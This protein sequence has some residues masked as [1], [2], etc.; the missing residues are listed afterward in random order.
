MVPEDRRIHTR[1][2]CIVGIALAV[3]IA[4]CG[5]PMRLTPPTTAEQCKILDVNAE[6]FPKIRVLLSARDRSGQPAR[7]V[8]VEKVT[9]E[10]LLDT[11]ET[12]FLELT[13]AEQASSGKRI[14]SARVFLVCDLRRTLSTGT[15]QA[16]VKDLLHRH[17]RVGHQFALVIS[18]PYHD[19][20]DSD[21]GQLKASLRAG[22]S[23]DRQAISSAISG[24]LPRGTT[25]SLV[26]DGLSRALNVIRKDSP[27]DQA[28]SAVVV[29]SGG[30]ILGTSVEAEQAQR[31]V[32]ELVDL[33]VSVVV[34][35]FDPPKA[36][37]APT[38][39]E[40]QELAKVTGGAFV[41]WRTGDDSQQA[42]AVQSKV[43]ELLNHLHCL[44]FKSWQLDPERAESRFTVKL[45]TG[46][47]ILVGTG[48]FETRRDVVEAEL[49]N[50]IRTELEFKAEEARQCLA[51]V[52]A[53]IK[54]CSTK[55]HDADEALRQGEP[56]RAL[57]YVDGAWFESIQGAQAE[58]DQLKTRRDDGTLI[59]VDTLSRL[60]RLPDDHDLRLKW[61]RA[62]EQIKEAESRL[63]GWDEEGHVPGRQADRMIADARDQQSLAA[64]LAR[65]DRPSVKLQ[66]IDDL[67]AYLHAVERMWPEWDGKAA[68]GIRQRFYNVAVEALE[69]V[70]R[71]AE[72]VQHPDIKRL[73]E[74]ILELDE[75]LTGTFVLSP[76]PHRLLAEICRQ[77]D[78]FA[79]AKDHCWK[80]HVDRGDESREMFRLWFDTCLLGGPQD[81]KEAARVVQYVPSGHD[82]LKAQLLMR[83]GEA[84]RAA[85]TPH[86]QQMLEPARKAY[87]EAD[88]LLSESD[89]ARATRVEAWCHIGDLSSQLG[90]LEDAVNAYEQALELADLAHS[91]S[92]VFPPD[93]VVKLMQWYLLL[94]GADGQGWK[95]VKPS[96]EQVPHLERIKELAELIL[97]EPLLSSADKGGALRAR[98]RA[99][100]LT[101]DPVGAAADVAEAKRLLPSDAP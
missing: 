96:A 41:R 95:E 58:V 31:I 89:G 43:T 85:S 88:K 8:T 6:Q 98:G 69:S 10:N 14:P 40:L 21:S 27:I 20:A 64:N 62:K 32:D 59:L 24:A 51:K 80:A 16:A 25:R 78:E 67:N 34:V 22:L 73:A 2:T 100:H 19:V 92:A 28:R 99:R 86:N 70:W 55:L 61:D 42:A 60:D 72:P 15:M 1:F 74:D 81:L 45:R 97:E 26:Y 39:A 66:T 44:E 83:L 13:T 87:K 68:V 9:E 29:F 35:A 49:A 76:V 93:R 54:R 37:T 77:R 38:H 36:T 30:A 52:N 79:E 91:P 53:A 75:G 33:R 17:W 3:S 11:E 5:T 7:N 84:Y 63:A 4:G 48:S 82:D 56:G 65:A 57:L 23:P 18:D 46:A 47:E 12:R 50:L 101:G 90:E 71:P 94:A